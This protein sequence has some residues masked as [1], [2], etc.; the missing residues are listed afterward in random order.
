MQEVSGVAGTNERP[1]I[2]LM[3]LV[4]AHNKKLHRLGMGKVVNDVLEQIVIPAQSSFIF[5]K[6]GGGSEV[7][8]ANLT[9]GT[10]VPADRDQEM[11][12]TARGFVL[13]MQLHSAVGSSCSTQKN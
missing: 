4:G 3:P 13:A 9:A 5:V 11:L 7:F 2:L 12:S 1:V 10:G 6:W 8:F